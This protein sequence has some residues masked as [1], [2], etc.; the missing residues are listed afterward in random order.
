MPQDKVAARRHRKELKRKAKR[1]GLA[2][3]SR[4]VG[5]KG[6]IFR[7]STG[8][9]SIKTWSTSDR[10]GVKQK[11]VCECRHHLNIHHEKKCRGD[12]GECDCKK[13]K[14]RVA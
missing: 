1:R 13:F 3:L 2:K 10:R 12:G 7:S 14:K 11:M 5:G 4:A 8:G 9:S 6:K